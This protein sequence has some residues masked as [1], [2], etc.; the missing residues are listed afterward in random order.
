M[1]FLLN[2][3]VLHSTQDLYY[4]L[5]R[6]KLQV[7]RNSALRRN[8]TM[9]FVAHQLSTWLQQ[10]SSAG[11][12]VS[13]DWK[14]M[15]G[16]KVT[17]QSN[18][19]DLL[20]MLHNKYFAVGLAKRFNDLLILLAVHMDWEVS[21]M[22]YLTCKPPNSRVTNQNFKLAFPALYSRLERRLATFSNVYSSMLQDFDSK[23]TAVLQA[24][25]LARE[26]RTR[27][28]EGLSQYQATIQNTPRYAWPRYTYIDENVE[29]C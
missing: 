22:Y 6:N 24:S 16:A 27:Y 3:S 29:T 14:W 10:E 4:A 18:A 8:I 20:S 9:Q 19:K 1:P 23:F 7:C 2:F 28:L 11:P 12:A 26:T 21:F 15:L 5:S 25:P 13:H 17:S